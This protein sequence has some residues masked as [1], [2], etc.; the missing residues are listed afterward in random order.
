M[1]DSVHRLGLSTRFIDSVYRLGS[2]TRFIDSHLGAQNGGQFLVSRKATGD[3]DPAA[4][5]ANAAPPDQ[6]TALADGTM[7]IVGSSAYLLVGHDDKSI[8]GIDV[9]EYTASEPYVLIVAAD[10]Q[11]RLAWTSFTASGPGGARAVA[12]GPDSAAIL[13]GQSAESLAEGALITREAVQPAPA[14]DGEAWLA[15][16]PTP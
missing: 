7:V 10:F 9:G 6:I 2:S 15:V 5:E 16:F 3:E 12:V 11:S 4:A 1:L 13:F 14:G 8:D